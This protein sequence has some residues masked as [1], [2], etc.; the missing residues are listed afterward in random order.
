MSTINYQLSNRLRLIALLFMAIILLVGYALRVYHLDVKDI[1]VDEAYLWSF[2]RLPMAESVLLGFATGPINSNADPLCNILLHVWI[3]LTGHS[4][5]ALRYFSVLVNLIGAAYLGRVTARVFGARAGKVALAVGIIAPLWLF[6][7]QEIRPYALTP[8]LMLIM[9]DAVLQIGQGKY[10]RVWPWVWLIIGEVLALY[11]HGF[12][13]FGVLGINLWLGALWLRQMRHPWHWIWLR[14]WSASQVAALMLLSPSIPVYLA[15]TGGFSNPFVPP[16]TGPAFANELWAYL[17]G[18]PREQAT[19]FIPMHM[20]VI[21]ALI[22]AW[23]GLSISLRRRTAR[24]LADLV[25]LVLGIASLAFVYTLRDPSV[26]PRY[27]VFLTGPL[28]IVLGVVIA[29]VWEAGRWKRWP[30]VLLA[31][32]LALTSAIGATN[33][34]E[35]RYSGYRHAASRAVTDTLKAEFGAQDG[36]IM[37]DAHD[38]TLD[39]Y[40]IGE[41]PLGWAR[42]D[43]GIDS[44]ASVVAFIDGKQRIAL[45]RNTN[46][47]SDRRKIVP[48]YLE[49]FGSLV[50]RQYFSGYDLATYRLDAGV[51]PELMTL[52]PVDFSWGFL[53]LTRKSVAS[54]DAVTVAIEWKATADFVPGTRYAASIRLVDPT[55]EW[56]IAGDDALLLDSNGYP[57]DHWLPGQHTG[58]YFVLPLQP[59]TPPI[60]AEL[61]VTLYNTV[62]GQAINLQDANG[63][64]M[65][66]QAMIG[67]VT[68]GPAPAQW[69][70]EERRFW[71]LSPI[72]DSNLLSGYAL[73]KPATSPGGTLGVTLSW[74]ISPNELQD[75]QVTLQLVQGDQIVAEDDGSALQGRRPADVS[76]GQSWLDRRLLHVSG[77]AQSG[78]ADLVLRIDRDRIFLTSLEIAGFERI[79]QLPDIEVPLEA[80]FGDAIRLLGYRLDIPDP[81]TSQ[82]TLTLTLYWQALMD[83]APD[84]NIKVTAQMLGA[85]GGVVG[86][87]DGVPVYESRPFSG[88]LAGEYIIDEHPM[89]FHEPYTGPIRIQIGL[90]DPIT[91]LRL[92]TTEGSDAVELPIILTVE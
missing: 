67:T 53:D 4:L 76:A 80:T 27:L 20:P 48:F 68:L 9:I 30:G 10:R 55:T 87:H 1:W 74:L 62:T 23:V 66:Q 78:P 2:A 34:Y 7:S 32:M 69:A 92:L 43:D 90:Y 81:L 21:M 54:G 45:L 47:I 44:I 17:M 14:N 12:M 88:W 22:L 60:D 33:L 57:T 51:S 24:P 18:I 72:E 16:V 28:F 77:D 70:Y 75:K 26:H 15:R 79:L 19:D 59:G 6:Y 35:G 37:V 71:Q 89:T 82:D 3:V 65:G 40:G 83:G 13:A 86:Q 50:S 5:F 56:I 42:L 52:E 61:I 46:E 8:A 58:Q 11:T 31:T 85:N 25:W 49:R 29:D 39:Y 63:A 64:P 41:A 91:G 73:A 36:I 84:A 38:F